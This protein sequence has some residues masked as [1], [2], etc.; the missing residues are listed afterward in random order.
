MINLYIADGHFDLLL[1]ESLLIEHIRQRP[2][3]QPPI[4]KTL[5]TTSHRKCLTG[6]SLSIGKDCAVIPVDRRVN[7]ILG[8]LIKDLFLFGL[9]VEELVEGKDALLLLVVNVAFFGVF[10][11]EELYFALL[12]VD[13]EAFVDL[14]GRADSEND[15]NGLV[16]AHFSLKF[17]FL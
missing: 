5:S 10:G 12:A 6:P 2:G 4:I 9:H 15:V 14:F 3:N 1:L 17:K 13:F 8:D 7:Y 11:G 16:L